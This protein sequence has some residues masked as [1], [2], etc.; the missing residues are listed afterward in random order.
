MVNGEDG[1][2]K[3]IEQ[4]NELDGKITT[5]KVKN[6]INISEISKE[7]ERKVIENLAKTSSQAWGF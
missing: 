1:V 4:L 7:I 5:V 6:K 3:L 2:Q